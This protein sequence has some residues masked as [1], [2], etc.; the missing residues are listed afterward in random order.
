M[1]DAWTFY[2]TG[3][4]NVVFVATDVADFKRVKRVLLTSDTIDC[5][6]FGGCEIYRLQF[7]VGQSAHA[8]L[9]AQ[10]DN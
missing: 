5:E 2:S 1:L 9:L 6:A 3:H 7:P 10:R 8:Y 4:T